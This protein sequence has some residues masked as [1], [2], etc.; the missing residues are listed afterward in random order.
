VGSTGIVLVVIA[1]VI[2][3]VVVAVLLARRGSNQV[4]P[5]T[6]EPPTPARPEVAPMSGLETALAQVTDRS[7]RPIG[8]SIDA[9]ASHVDDLRIPDDT[10]P[11]LRRALDHVTPRSDEPVADGTDRTN[12]EA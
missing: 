2:V 6:T 10:G 3:A 1:V 9:E 5:Q 12:D 7:G 4:A 11:V 8:E